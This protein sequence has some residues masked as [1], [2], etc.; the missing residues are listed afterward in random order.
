[1]EYLGFVYEDPT[2]TNS[3]IRQKPFIVVNPA[4]KASVCVKHIIGRIEKG[5]IVGS[6]GVSRF[7]KKFL[8]KQ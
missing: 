8:E 6:H 4:S 7:L 1:V 3:V 2:V 5:E